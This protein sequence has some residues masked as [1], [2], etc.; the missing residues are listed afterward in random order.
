MIRLSLV[1][2]GAAFSLLLSLI[3]SIA[4][5]HQFPGEY[6]E[7][8][9]R[10]NEKSPNQLFIIGM[11]HRD[12]LT[13]LNGNRTSRVQ[14][15]VYKI[16]DWLVHDQGLQ[17]LLPEGFF[18]KTP[19]RLQEK[20]V[21]TKAENGSKCGTDLSDMRAIEERLSDNN[22]FVNAEML[23]NERHHM[24]IR[25]I[26]DEKSYEAARSSVQKLVNCGNNSRDYLA[27]KSELNYLQEKRTAAMLQRI[28]GVIDEEFRQGTIIARKA[29]FTIGMSH[30]HK[31]IEYLNKGRIK[32]F[33]PLIASNESEDYIA[34]VNLLKE[35]FGISIV[36]PR[37]L[38]NDQKI[39]EMNKLD[40]II[41]RSR[42]MSTMMDLALQPNLTSN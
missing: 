26:E 40:K 19:A 23:L 36:I 14:A 42:N 29:L 24:R 33:S 35:D 30:L 28:P 7:V 8:I 16:G 22:I 11:S 31:I 9:H 18:S 34:D 1:A 41:S 27:V 21:K 32:I 20:K 6:G 5:N 2:I 25:Q 12:S 17:L 3:P 39:L 10:S 4:E 15:E 37:M 13:R 38:A